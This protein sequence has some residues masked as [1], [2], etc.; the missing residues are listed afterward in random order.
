MRILIGKRKYLWSLGLLA[1]LIMT[2][3]MMTNPVS[4]D[5][6]GVVASFDVTAGVPG[7]AS[8]RY[9]GNYQGHVWWTEYTYYHLLT[10]YRS[11]MIYDN[12][13]NVFDPFT[14]IDIYKD[15]D[16]LFRVPSTDFV[17]DPAFI[18]AG[19]H[20]QGGLADYNY[21]IAGSATV[22]SRGNMGFRLCAGGHCAS[23]VH[24]YA[25]WDLW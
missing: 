25:E 13:N 24:M 7:S 11:D 1:A 8:Q 4:A 21:W 14:N 9:Q 19:W 16:F 22:K 20:R 23:G 10:T 15:G 18:P 2:T 12:N 3:T 17:A 5:S 6:A